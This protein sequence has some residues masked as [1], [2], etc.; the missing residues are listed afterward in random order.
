MRSTVRDVGLE[1]TLDR[2]HDAGVHVTLEEF[3]GRRPIER[4]GLSLPLDLRAFENPLATPHYIASTGGSRGTPRRVSVDLALLEQEGAYHAA[5]P[6][7]L[8]PCRE[9][10]CGLARDP[11][12]CLRHQQPPAPG[13]DRR[14]PWRAGSTPTAL[15]VTREAVKFALFTHYTVRA[16]RLAG[17]KLP[18]PEYCPPEDGERVARWLAEMTARGHA[19]RARHSG[20]PRR[21]GVPGRSRSRPRH[22]RHLLPLRRRALYRGEGR[23]RGRGGRNGGVPLHDGRDRAD[24]RGVRRRPRRSTTCTCSATGSPS[25]SATGRS[26]ARGLTVGA[27][28]YTTLNASS[29]KLMINVESDDYGVLEERA[30]GCVLGELGPDAPPSRHPQLREADERGQPLPRRRPA[31]AGGRDPA[32]PIRWPAHRLPA[33]RGGGA[34]AAEGERR[35]PPGRRRGGRG[36]TSWPRW[37]TTS[38]PSRATG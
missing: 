30:C 34:R 10:V 12:E 14:L 13:Q 28:H 8:R 24:R 23:D 4:P 15:R 32:P 11:A 16:G 21:A 35:D 19:R 29:P 2:L 17:A 22:R 1:A 9:A 3:K 25:S 27:L 7:Q 26:T 31:R 18:A 5:V 6:G 20:R 37:W 38:A 36:E 33:R